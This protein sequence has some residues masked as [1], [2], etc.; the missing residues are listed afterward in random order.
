MR[1]EILEFTATG[2]PLDVS[3]AI[4]QHATRQGSLNA[5]VVPWESDR[6]TLSMAVTS[7]KGHG[8]D[9]E[10]TNLGTIK[11]TGLGEGLT[12]VVIAAHQPDHV[13]RQKLAALFDGFAQQIQ[14]RLQVA[15]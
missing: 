10:H 7:A 2:S 13:E 3:R 15:P 5:I 11:L 9:R 14:S 8:W 1:E 4:E 12:R 6:I